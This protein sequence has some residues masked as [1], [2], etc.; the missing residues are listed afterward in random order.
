[1]SLQIWEKYLPVI[2]ILIKRSVNGDQ[3]FTLNSTDFK[4]YTAAKKNGQSFSIRFSDGFVVN[5]IA[6]SVAAKDLASILTDN[7]D[8]KSLLAN[9]DYEIKMTTKNQIAI[10]HI[11]KTA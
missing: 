1:M 9:G 5:N 10:K 8:I 6:A 4:Q 11:S 7:A 2:K 3:V